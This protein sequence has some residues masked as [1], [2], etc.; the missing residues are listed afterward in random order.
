MTKINRRE[1]KYI[2]DAILFDWAIKK[3]GDKYFWEGDKFLPVEIGRIA[4]DLITRGILTVNKETGDIKSTSLSKKLIC[5]T[6]CKSEISHVKR[7]TVCE[8]CEGTGLMLE[9]KGTMK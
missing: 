5:D 7:K 4:T 9:I 1:R 6:G 8:V 2:G 3:E